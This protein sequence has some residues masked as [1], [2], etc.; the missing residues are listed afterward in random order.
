MILNEKASE[1]INY[2]FYIVLDLSL[3]VVAQLMDNMHVVTRG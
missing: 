1:K 3:F 2:S